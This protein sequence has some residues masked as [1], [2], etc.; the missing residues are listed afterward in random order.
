MSRFE[1]FLLALM[2]P[3]AVGF[4]GLALLEIFGAWV[5]DRGT[6]MGSLQEMRINDNATIGSEG[7]L[8]L[9]RE[10]A[11]QAGIWPVP[12][13]TALLLA[14][15]TAVLRSGLWTAGGKKQRKGEMDNLPPLVVDDNDT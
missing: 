2:W 15:G 13:I 7:Q 10:I 4:L 1:R 6:V 5:G 12:Q 9:G 3:L 11:S 8:D 14:L